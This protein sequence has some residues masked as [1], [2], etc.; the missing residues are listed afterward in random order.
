MEH[1]KVDIV[2][3]TPGR[4]EDLISTGK[5]ALSSVRFFVLDEADG[6]LSQGYGDLINRLHGQIPKVTNDGKRLQMVVCS[7]TLHSFDVKKMAERLMYFPTWIDLKGQDSVPETVHHCVC[8]IDP[9]TDTRWKTFKTNIQTDGVHYE[10]N[11]QSHGSTP[12]MSL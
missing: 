4:L 6:L 11:I 10:D 5:L 12:G 9:Q 2:V 7:A 1:Q 8:M 3:G